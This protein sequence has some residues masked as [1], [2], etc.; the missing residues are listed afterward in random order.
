VGE[1][2]VCDEKVIGFDFVL[3][4]CE[5]VFVVFFFGVDEDDVEDVLDL[6]EV[7]EGVFGD[8]F[9]GFVE[10]CFCDVGLLGVDLCGICF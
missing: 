3:C 2:V 8:E 4:E 5:E 10:I 1:N 9:D 7:G 6:W